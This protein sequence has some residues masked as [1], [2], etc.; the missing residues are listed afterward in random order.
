M[1]NVRLNG[2]VCMAFGFVHEDCKINMHLCMTF[3]FAKAEWENN[4][5]DFHDFWL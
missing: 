4:V 3:D 5:L 2:L 1:Q